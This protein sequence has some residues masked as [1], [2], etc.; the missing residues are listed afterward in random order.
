MKTLLREIVAGGPLWKINGKAKA[1]GNTKY[2]AFVS[3][4]FLKFNKTATT[5]AM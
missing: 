3:L 4:N 2:R 1:V 5:K